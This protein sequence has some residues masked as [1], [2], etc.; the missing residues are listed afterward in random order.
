M[1]FVR[2]LNHYYRRTPAL[3]R[4]DADYFGFHWIDADKMDDNTYFYYRSDTQTPLVEDLDGSGDT[5]IADLQDIALVALNLSGKDYVDYD[6]GVPK[7]S[8]YICMIDTESNGR[9]D[10][11]LRQG[12]IYQVKPGSRNG[13]DQYIT[14]PLPKLSGMILERR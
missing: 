7:A 8:Y 11:D 9:N 4:S 2:K 6:I 13:F 3:W 1:D 12:K 10:K 14:V 5:N